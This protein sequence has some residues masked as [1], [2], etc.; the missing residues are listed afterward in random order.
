[1]KKASKKSIELQTAYVYRKNTPRRHHYSGKEK[2]DAVVNI[3]LF[4]IFFA[5]AHLHTASKAH[6]KT[7]EYTENHFLFSV[8]SYFN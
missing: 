1:M 4:T 6:V 3:S 2:K 5:S 7:R 8:Y